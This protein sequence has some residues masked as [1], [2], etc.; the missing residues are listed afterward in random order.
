MSTSRGSAADQYELRY[1]ENQLS[2]LRRDL[3]SI[4]DQKVNE[5]A[6]QSADGAAARME[7]FNIRMHGLETEAANFKLALRRAK[8]ENAELKEEVAELRQEVA[9]LTAK[10][11]SVE[12]LVEDHPR[13]YV[14]SYAM[15]VLLLTTAL[16]VM[17]CMT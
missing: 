8:H 16:K 5:F 10:L 7:P 17:P 2:E 4:I 12:D 3:Y 15:G 14:L 13:L 1:T 6:R 11:G 9:G